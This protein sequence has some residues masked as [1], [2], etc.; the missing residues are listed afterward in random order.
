MKSKATRKL[1]AAA[2]IGALYAVLTVVL[3]PISYGPVQFRISE[4]LCILPF[5]F[6]NAAWGLTVGCLIANLF[7]P[8]GLLDI[9]FGSLATLLAALCTA[10]IGIK[11]RAAA[12]IGEIPADTVLNGG[13]AT[14]RKNIGYSPCILACL[15]P[16]LFN[17]GIVGAEL[18][19]LSVSR[20]LFWSTFALYAAEVGGGEAAV[21]FVLGL[22]AMRYL[23]KDNKLAAI[24]REL[25]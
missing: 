19:W 12:G 10:K 14:D 9:L 3:E 24:L 22:P 13:A 21:L 5:F 1:T 20:E 16:V 8:N 2:V 25:R 18:A 4:V 17:A 7:G 6:P 15:M 11:A 23:M